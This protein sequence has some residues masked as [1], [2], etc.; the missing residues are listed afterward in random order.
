MADRPES[1]G[2]S[3]ADAHQRPAKMRNGDPTMPKTEANATSDEVSSCRPRADRDTALWLPPVIVFMLGTAFLGYRSFVSDWRGVS[4]L[5]EEIPAAQPMEPS[6]DGEGDAPKLAQADATE[7]DVTSK[8]TN[9]A[10]PAQPPLETDGPKLADN[11]DV[12]SQDDAHPRDAEVAPGPAKPVEPASVDPLDDIRREAE[13]TRERIAELER[14]KKKEEEKLAQTEEE[15]RQ[16][17]QANRRQNLEKQL[18]AHRK[19]FERQVAMMEEFQKR[20]MEQFEQ[21][22]REFLAGRGLPEMPN[23]GRLPRGFGAMPPGFFG[24]PRIVPPHL[25]RAPRL[26]PPPGQRLP[27][28]IKRMPDGTVGRFREF[29]GP[30]GMRGFVFQYNS[31]DQPPN[32]TPPPP[33][34]DPDL[35]PRRRAPQID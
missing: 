25:N 3:G 20:S 22:E 11:S 35:K 23:F 16:D 33:A 4:A 32:D 27:E 8:P 21:M 17:D 12:Q 6:R 10:P 7:P 19:L 2:R 34:P 26:A 13:K 24:P 15:R 1:S 30:N 5:F 18:E 9:D 28:E 29:Q 31:E 14:I